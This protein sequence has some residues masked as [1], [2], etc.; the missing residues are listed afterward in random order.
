LHCSPINAQPVAKAAHS[1]LPH[2][3]RPLSCCAASTCSPPRHPPQVVATNARKLL[4]V[5]LSF[6]LFPKPLSLTSAL[7]GVA[8]VAGIAVRSAS[9]KDKGEKRE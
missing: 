7:S 3:M 6:I 4:T 9:K 1:Q 2:T 8:V 5:G